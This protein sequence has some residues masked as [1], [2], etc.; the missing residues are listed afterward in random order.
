MFYLRK[1]FLWADFNEKE[2][3]LFDDSIEQF[4]LCY[5]C[6]VSVV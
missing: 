3:Y 4:L 6:S 1:A 5:S 2:E